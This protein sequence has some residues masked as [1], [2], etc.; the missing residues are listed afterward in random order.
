MNETSKPTDRAWAELQAIVG[1]EYVWPASL[2]DVIDQVTPAGII[3]P[4]TAQQVAQVLKYCSA[5]GLALVPRG[6]GTKLAWGNRP[7][8]FDFILSTERLNHVLEHAWGD[9]TVTVEAGCT[10]ASL[11]HTLQEHGQRLAADPLWP[12]K[13]TVGGLLAT[14]D[15][16]TLRIRYG[17]V[18]DLVLGVEVALSDGNLIK[19]GG[20]VVKNVAGYDLTRLVIGSLGTLGV[21]T[22]VVFRLHPIPV[23]TATYSTLLATPV[24][25]GKL[26]LAILGSSLVYTGLQLRAQAAGQIAVDIRFEGIPESLQDQFVKLGQVAAGC[27]FA[28]GPDEIWSSRQK[29][30]DNTSNAVV[31]KCSVL[32]ADLGALGDAVFRQAES[33]KVA[34]TVVAQGT[35]VAEVRLESTAAEAL[36]AAVTA[37]R[38]EL[39]RLQGTLVVEQ[40]PAPM[41]GTLD[42]WGTL[43]EGLP[44]MQKIKEKF[45]PARTLNPG[46]FVGAI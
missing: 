12:D 45:D 30:F 3:A 40:C 34:A 31:C 4:G 17:A 21:I 19:A 16:G 2:S 35:G 43:H 15:S 9:M 5:A 29:L 28:E 20:K 8:K 7:R 42:V 24:E 41:K 27:P 13:S 44:L 25:A 37:L 39:Q 11:Q 14:A 18:R 26:V 38:G 33:A 46:R 36:L 6:G 22:R 23:A 32:P 10:I 1:H